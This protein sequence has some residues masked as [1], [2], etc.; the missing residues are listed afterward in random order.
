MGETCI[1]E[2]GCMEEDGSSSSE[3]EDSDFI[4]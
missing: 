1:E 2:G 4:D 3:S